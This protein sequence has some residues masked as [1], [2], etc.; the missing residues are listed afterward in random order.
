[1]RRRLLQW[2]FQLRIVAQW[3]LVW[4]ALRGRLSGLV[5]QVVGVMAVHH[6]GH[7]H[8]QVFLLL[9]LLLLL[10]LHLLLLLLLLLLLQ[11]A[12]SRSQPQGSRRHR[13]AGVKE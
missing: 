7:W 2:V 1:M 10:L 5:I 13:S 6:Y 9:L 12:G 4:S 8:C 11:R 3:Q